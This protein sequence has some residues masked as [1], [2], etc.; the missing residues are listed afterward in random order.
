ME[1]LP[2][3]PYLYESD[4]YTIQT[5]EFRIQEAIREQLFLELGEEIPYASYVE[6]DHIEN[7]DTLMKIHAY[8]HVESESQK[9]IMIGK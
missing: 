6:V 3:G 9:I 5:M 8:V 2:E 7:T 4:Y 1:H